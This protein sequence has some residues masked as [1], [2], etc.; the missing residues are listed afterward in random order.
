MENEANKIKDLIE[1]IMTYLPTD[2]KYNKHVEKFLL[3]ALGHG[4]TTLEDEERYEILETNILEER[5]YQNVPSY[6]REE[7][8]LLWEAEKALYDEEIKDIY[9]EAYS[10]MASKVY[11]LL[12][13]R[14]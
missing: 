10:K 1:E 7:D 5:L 11:T 9:P 3:N 4:F 8:I 12:N 13:E 2:L 14:R 6:I